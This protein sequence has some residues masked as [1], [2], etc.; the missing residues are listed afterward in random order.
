MG[1]LPAR[2]YKDGESQCELHRTCKALAA[3]GP[4]DKVQSA[5]VW[6]DKLG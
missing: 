4:T 6:V 1:S 5:H 2:E 3:I